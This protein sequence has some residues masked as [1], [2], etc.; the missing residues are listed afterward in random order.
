MY[1]KHVGS[2]WRFAKFFGGGFC[3]LSCAVSG[4]G[5]FAR[6][7]GV[8]TK[9]NAGRFLKEYQK[10]EDGTYPHI[11]RDGNL[12]NFVFAFGWSR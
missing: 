6:R 9:S 4:V 2:E 8:Q 10:I 12:W 7:G 11:I 1:L 3:R 5:Y